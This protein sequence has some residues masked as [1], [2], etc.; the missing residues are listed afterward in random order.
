MKS[1]LF[2][3]LL[4][5]SSLFGVTIEGYGYDRSMSE[6]KKLA[7]DDLSNN[8]SIYVESDYSSFV[9]ESDREFNKKIVSL[10]NIKS[11]LPII[12]ASFSHDEQKTVAKLSSK[13]ALHLYE[14]KLSD[15]KKELQVLKKKIDTAKESGQMYALY[16]LAL[17]LVQAY[18]KHEIVALIL[19]HKRDKAPKLTQSYIQAKMIELSQNITS[20]ELASK[21][22]AT[23]FLQKNIYLYPPS[24]S[25]SNEVTPFARVLRDNLSSKLEQAKNPATSQYKLVGSYE[26]SKKGAFVTYNLLDAKNNSLASASIF[27]QKSAYDG[28]E[29]E[30]KNLS[31]DEEIELSSSKL[32]SNL[33]VDLSIK[34]FGSKSVLLRDGDDVELV[35]KANRQAYFYLLGHVLHE[36]EKF[37]YLVELQDGVGKER[38]IYTIGATDVNKPFLLPLSFSVSEPFGY[39]SLH[40]FA[41]TEMPDELPKCTMRDGYCIIGLKPQEVVFKTR[42]LKPKKQS[43]Q[44]AE[45]VLNFTTMKSS[46]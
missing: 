37:S 1:L 19:G 20:I 45:A 9:N 15:F 26:T 6:S 33:K 31:F 36:D 25:G 41:S 13:D 46:L 14:Q 22:L 24:A 40:M 16:E 10:I 30:P 7:L 2:G 43:V 39:E 32:K 12:G 18:E 29:I 44:K 8:I 17:S 27:I 35:V 38:F 11:E 34:D 21:I 3:L 42:G 28:V 4:L 23:K 5:G